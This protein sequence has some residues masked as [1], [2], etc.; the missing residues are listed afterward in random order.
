MSSILQQNHAFIPGIGPEVHQATFAPCKNSIQGHTNAHASSS[1]T[2]IA[3]SLHM[4]DVVFQ[5]KLWRIKA[6]AWIPDAGRELGMRGARAD[7]PVA[8]RHIRC[9]RTP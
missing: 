5:P 3:S 6:H 2:L 8:G 1:F 9:W 4:P 7:Q